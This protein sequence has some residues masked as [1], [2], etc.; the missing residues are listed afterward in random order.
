ML[1]ENQWDSCPPGSEQKVGTPPPPP[2][3]ILSRSVN[4]SAGMFCVLEIR[5]FRCVGT[6]RARSV[7]VYLLVAAVVHSCGETLHPI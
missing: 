5:Q 1:R 2:P 6:E 4:C 3:R 7:T